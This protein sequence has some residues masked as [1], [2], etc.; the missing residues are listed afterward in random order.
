MNRKTHILAI[1]LLLLVSIL[2]S[3]AGESSASPTPSATAAPPTPSEAPVDET[4]TA[5]AEEDGFKLPIAESLT[6]FEVWMP[7]GLSSAGM[8]S[9]NDSRAYQE[10]ERLTNIHIEWQHP[11]Q[12]SEAETFNLIMVSQ[13]YPDAM[14]CVDASYY[15]G[16][17]DKYVDED[18]ILDLTDLIS[19][20]APNYNDLRNSDDDIRRRTMTDEGRVPYFRTINKT[21]QPSFFGNMVR[22]D[23]LDAAG[24]TGLPETYSEFHDMLVALKDQA[25]TAPLYLWQKTGLDEQLMVGYGVNSSWYQVDGEVK[26]GPIEPGFKEY[27]TM[28]NQWY[29][30]GLVDPEF[31]GRAGIFAGDKALFLNGEFGA[32]FHFYTNIDLMEYEAENES[33]TLSAVTPPVPNKGDKRHMTYHA[34]PDA[35]VGGGNATITTGCEDPVMMTK[36]LN[37]F[38][39]EEGSLIGN[40]GIEGESYTIVD[41]KPGFTDLVL[42]NPDG[43][44]VNDATILYTCGP[45]HPKWYDWERELTPTMSDKAKAAGSVWD[46]NWENTQ[47]LPDITI[48]SDESA[49][50]S[51]IYTDINTLIQETTAAFIS[52]RKPLSEFDDFVAEIKR[53]NIDRCIEI[54]QAALDRYYNR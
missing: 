34:I 51:F 27:I 43:L 37:F 53:M 12:G 47:T 33:F 41:G 8:E 19:E 52:N 6:T 32:F 35:M 38:Y 20:Y 26:F 10:A 45:V 1:A 28:M 49:E 14:M 40:Y 4:Q 22:Q 7:I 18:I 30:E 39:T 31:F 44:S 13:N 16:G 5:P 48:S 11:I 50:Y 9:A 15:V 42:N 23:W 29:S 2:T 24:Y 17:Y 3:C 46:A 25:G 21:L 36:W 54:Q